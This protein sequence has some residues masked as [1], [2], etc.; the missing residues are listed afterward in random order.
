MSAGYLGILLHAHLPYVRH[1]EHERFYE[2]NW[3]FEAVTETYLP[4]LAMCER[5]LR[6][7]I[8][9]RLTISLSPTLVGMM[10]DR[11]LHERYL[12]HLSGLIELAGKEV[13]RTRWNRRFRPL[14]RM[15]RDLFA[16]TLALYQTRYRGDLVGAFRD[17]QNAGV[18]E[19]MTCAATHGYLPLLRAEPSAVRAQ[20]MIG[21][22]TYTKA[23]GMPPRGIWLPECG[24]YPGL[25]PILKAAGFKYFILESHGILHSDPRPRFGV[26]APVSCPNGVA[27]FGRDPESSKLVW[28]AT[29][30]YPGDLEYRD[31]YR[32][33]GFDLDEKYVGPY[34]LDGHIRIHTGI[35]YHRITGRTEQKEP[36]RPERARERAAVHAEHFLQQKRAQLAR[37]G[38]QMDRPPF[39]LAPFDAELFGHWWFEGPL[40]LEDLVR[41][42]HAHGNGLSLATPSDYLERHPYLQMAQPSASSWGYKGYNE[43][44]LSGVNDWIY[45]HLRHAS[46][47]LR[48]L[49]NQFA[50]R[51]LDPLV[52]RALKQ[53]ARNLLLA[54]ASDWPFIM[55][56]GSSQD[57]ARKRVCDHLA[58]FHYIEHAVRSGRIDERRLAAL[59]F[60]D[61][62]FPDLDVRVFKD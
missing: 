25:D 6:D 46:R 54:Q 14:A 49:A 12:R 8:Q 48:A 35:K 30:G 17:M 53:A 61:N 41:N 5:L 16:D 42:I 7:E 43:Y 55:R 3:Y 18:L 32:D 23:F 50:D 62:I 26:M 39:I 4:L 28:S 20:V 9:C 19:I 31:F 58:R 37:E 57:Y 27:A 44:W 45:P 11:L 51:P 34:I 52:D 47:S 56:T 33:I 22:D 40:W 15:Y 60:L 29:E 21:A 24:Y 2:E 10:Q 1:P 59:E 36:Y 13:R 38:S